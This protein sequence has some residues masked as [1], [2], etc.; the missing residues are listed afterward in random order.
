[1]SEMAS[2]VVGGVTRLVGPCRSRRGRGGECRRTQRQR[3]KR[4]AE[5]NQ[6]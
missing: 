3:N 6:L 1:M 2:G 4:P 5:R